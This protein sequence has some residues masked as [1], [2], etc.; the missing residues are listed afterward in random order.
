MLQ[1]FGQADK[2]C[3][4]GLPL[5]VLQDAGVCYPRT[6]CKTALQEVRYLSKIN[7]DSSYTRKKH[8]LCILVPVMGLH[9]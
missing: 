6:H 7:L 5:W 1:D 9:H 8:L 2:S 3:S 4:L